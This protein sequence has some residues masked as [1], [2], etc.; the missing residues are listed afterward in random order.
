MGKMNFNTDLSQ[1]RIER[2]QKALRGQAMGVQEISDAIFLSKRWM[3]SYITHL[4]S[5]GLIHI[6]CY[7]ERT[8]KATWQVAQYRWGKGTDAPQP[9]RVTSKEKQAK[10]R[11]ALKADPIEATFARLRRQALRRMPRRDGMVSAFFGAPA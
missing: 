3:H 8:D 4:H 5:A 2:I 6:E 7:R 9:P 11:A 1:R 10:A